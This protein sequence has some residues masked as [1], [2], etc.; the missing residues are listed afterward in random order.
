MNK[1]ELL[2]NQKLLLAR[3]A[4]LRQD[5]GTQ[6]AGFKQPLLWVD[7]LNKGWQWL[8]KNPIWPLGGMLAVLV[9]RP[10]RTLVIGFRLWSA[11]KTFKK[12]KKW[13]VSLPLQKIPF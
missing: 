9:L 10:K 2:L 8:R 7:G 5:F 12:I 1:S 13:F 6:A 4:R 11:W 3:S